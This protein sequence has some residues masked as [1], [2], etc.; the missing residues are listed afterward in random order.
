[1]LKIGL[2][3]TLN[4]GNSRLKMMTN[5]ALKKWRERKIIAN[6][7]MILKT[8]FFKIRVFRVE[9]MEETNPIPKK[10]FFIKISDIEITITCRLMESQR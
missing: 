4:K 8:H 5:M 10:N 1:M 6:I 3:I 9:T 2:K 7:C